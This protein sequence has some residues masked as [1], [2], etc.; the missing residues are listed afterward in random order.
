MLL[1]TTT[2]ILGSVAKI[3]GIGGST[4]SDNSEERLSVDIFLLF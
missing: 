4:C 2:E 3:N 1:H